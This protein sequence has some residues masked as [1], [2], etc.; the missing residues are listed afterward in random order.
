[1]TTTPAPLPGRSLAIPASFALIAAPALWLIG[2]IV[3][4]VKGHEGPGAAWT[5]A[6]AIWVFAVLL[7]GAAI[8][9]LHRTVKA[10]TIGVKAIAVTGLI[11]G[12]LGAASL[13]G[14]LCLD[15]YVGLEASTRESASALYDKVFD[16]PGVELVFFQIGPSMLFAGFLILPIV[17][18]ARRAV[19]PAAAVLVGSGIALMV[20]GR[21]FD[22]VLRLTEGLGMLVMLAG[23][24]IV[25]RAGAKR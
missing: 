15:L 19:P 2:W 8:V 1:M 16:T 3:M 25:V 4:R 5:G 9:V 6:H 7:F 11:L 14:Q 22:G 24:V 18:A 20:A 17:A 13:L 10:E 21:G 12:L 23:L